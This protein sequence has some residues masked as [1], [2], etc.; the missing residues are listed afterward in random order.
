MTGVCHIGVLADDLTGSLASAARL[1]ARGL[2]PAILWE[3][4]SPGAEHDA[5]VADMRTRDRPIE[6]MEAAGGWGA[7]LRDLGCRHL[8]LR[9]DSTLRGHT[10]LELR[11]LL[12]GAGLED[13]WV[14]AVPAFPDAGR[15]TR[16]GRQR[17]A[18]VST[19]PGFDVDVAAVLFPGQL[20]AGIGLGTVERGAP[21]IVAEVEAAA[22]RGVRRFV[23][24]AT[25]EQHLA[26]AAEA[27]GLLEAA[28][29]RLVTISPGAWLRYHP[30]RARPPAF[31]LLVVASPSEQNRAQLAA[32]LDGPRPAVVVDSERPLVDWSGL[33]DGALI[34]VETV[35]CETYR[36]RAAEEAARLAAGLLARAHR[37]G[38]RCGGVVVSGGHAASCLVDAL[39]ARAVVPVGELAPLCPLG[40]LRGGR[41]DGLPMATKGGLVGHPQTLIQIIETLEEKEPWQ[42]PAR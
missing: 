40:V 26:A 25:C 11:G 28:G 15:V 36:E 23:V 38:W 2:H 20:A 6:P 41:W 8:E 37:R 34:V 3:R 16:G 27:V 13:A 33:R 17:L 35:R 10:A 21:A 32:L 29:R 5:L 31:L 1:V 39:R 24:D 7:F 4:R 19:P 42:I 9:S 30:A 12:S 14:V 22:A 18:G